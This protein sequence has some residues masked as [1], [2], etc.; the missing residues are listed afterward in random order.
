MDF[1]LKLNEQLNAT[2]KELEQVL[3][4]K[5][6]NIPASTAEVVIGTTTTGQ[7]TEL[8]QGSTANL[9]TDELTKSMEEMKL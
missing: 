8:P 4:D 1:L 5:Q 3:K 6:T 2:E 9:N 7:P